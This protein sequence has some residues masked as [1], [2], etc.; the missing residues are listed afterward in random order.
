[1]TL[2]TPVI[3]LVATSFA[4]LAS[5]PAEAGKK[6]REMVQEMAPWAVDPDHVKLEIIE[7]LVLE[8]AQ[9]QKALPIIA[10]MR[11]EGV[12]APVLDL[13][14]GIAM[15]EEGMHSEA[16]ALLLEARRRMPTDPR[17]HDALCVLYA[18]EREL[19]KAVAACE[20]AT[21]LDP[22]RASAWNNLGYLYVVTN[23][24]SEAIEA[25]KA[26]IDLDGAEPRYRNNLAIARVANGEFDV[27]LAVFRTTGSEADALYN[28][29]FAVERTQGAEAALQWYRRAIE[30]DPKHSQAALAIDKL[31]L[32]EEPQ[33]T[34]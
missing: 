30:T 5:S 31:T 1:M 15:R 21:K 22:E 16:E 12:K 28:V 19:D 24:P 18:D 2:R 17:V 13:L 8:K 32:S 14:Q 9:Y 26:A 25:A 4:L 23:R 7:R 33:E 6:R 10:A 20:K 27:A 3:A 11:K 34:P 29:G